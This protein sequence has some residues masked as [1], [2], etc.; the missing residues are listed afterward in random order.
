VE[1]AFASVLSQVLQHPEVK[2]IEEAWRGL[3]LFIDNCDFRAGVQ[4][5][6]VPAHAAEVEEALI[7]MAQKLDPERG[8]VDLI[9]VDHRV[10]NVTVDLDRAAR[11]GE[12]AETYRAP[13]V[14]EGDPSL[15]GADSL[16]SLGQSMRRLSSQDDAR[17][18]QVRALAGKESSRWLAVAMNGALVRAPY[19]PQTS[20]IKDPPYQEDEAGHVF[21]SPVYVVGAVAARSYVKSGWPTAITGARDGGLG[22]LVVREIEDRGH[23][24]ALP[25]ET[26][27]TQDA[28]A[29]IARAGFLML[30]CAANSDTAIV[31]KAPMIYRGSTVGARQD[32]PANTTLGDQLFVGRLANALEQVAAA[33]PEGTDP[34]A[35]A[36]TAHLVIADLFGDAAPPGP[37]IKMWVEKGQLLLTIRPRRFAGVGL[38]EI[39]LGAKLG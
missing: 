25:L 20:R 15:L 7:G 11:W 16:A 27:V 23:K 5:D 38:E 26:F 4:V 33:I 31:A 19:T 18:A 10:R 12:I 6:V 34:K 36:E 14:V 3:K 22:N 17:T 24:M 30:T 2:R 9:L 39:T 8:P 35:A 28:H 29:E 1:Q 13:I 21:V 32:E 37:E